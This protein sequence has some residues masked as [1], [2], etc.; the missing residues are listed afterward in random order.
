[1][2]NN[3]LKIFVTVAEL[4]SITE[5]SKK[6]YISQPAVSQAIKKLENQFNVDL[7]IRNKKGKLLLT[8]IGMNILDL[9]YKMINLENQMYQITNDENNLKRGIIKI[10]SVPIG[11][12]LIL[13]KILPKFK[14]QYPDI[15]I[16][17]IEDNP[18]GVKE[19]ISNYA[20]DFGITTSPYQ[21][22]QHKFLLL[23]KMV[24]ISKE[25]SINVN[26]NRNIDNLIL[27]KV[28]YNSIIEQLNKSK[29]NL[30]NALIVDGASTQ[31][32]MIENNNG[33]GIMSELMLST[34]KNS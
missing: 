8:D 22:L 14:K 7:F 33:I 25:K 21:G 4:K 20:V 23:D 34:I 31:I 13:S 15:K 5:A 12:S 9:A 32:N 24:S 26:L 29:I 28:A 3:N 27:C 2:L 11:I 1:M 18:L 10:G 6:F 19:K 17:I 30:T 16:E